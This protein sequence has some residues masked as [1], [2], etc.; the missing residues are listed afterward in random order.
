MMNKPRF[1]TKRGFFLCMVACRRGSKRGGSKG[2]GP[3]GP[4][5]KG[6]RFKRYGSKRYQ[7]VGQCFSGLC[8][9]LYGFVWGLVWGHGVGFET[10]GLCQN[11]LCQKYRHGFG[12]HDKSVVFWP[13]GSCSGSCPGPVG[14][15][16][17]RVVLCGVVYG[18]V[19][20]PSALCV[21]LSVA[22]YGRC[23]DRWRPL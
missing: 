4:G 20:G 3:K 6:A 15:T 23:L 19:V 9:P 18:L 10:H 16:G 13:C 8:P 11:G 12:H 17:P 1:L 22:L 14:V 21:V 2:T 5:S 7:G